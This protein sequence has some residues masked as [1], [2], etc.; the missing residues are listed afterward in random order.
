MTTERCGNF[1]ERTIADVESTD[2]ARNLGL[3]PTDR[4]DGAP[5]PRLHGFRRGVFRSRVVSDHVELELLVSD[6]GVIEVAGLWIQRRWISDASQL[7]T[8]IDVYARFLQDAVGEVEAKDRE[9]LGNLL[10]VSYEQVKAFDALL[11]RFSFVPRD[12]VGAAA[13]VLLGRRMDASTMIRTRTVTVALRNDTSGR[14]YVGVA[15]AKAAF[16]LGDMLFHAAP[17]FTRGDRAGVVGWRAPDIENTPFGRRFSLELDRAAP[18]QG[19]IARRYYGSAKVPGSI[20]LEVMMEPTRGLAGVLLKLEQAWM[21][22]SDRNFFAALEIIAAFVCEG[23]GDSPDARARVE[24]GDFLSVSDD[25]DDLWKVLKASLP[26]VARGKNGD[27]LEVFL[28]ERESAATFMDDDRCAVVI[29]ENEDGWL[30]VLFHLTEL[31]EDIGAPAVA[32][33]EKP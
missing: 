4:G 2:F 28:G 33:P 14:M 7:G 1:L 16:E 21:E 29:H 32:A 19:R 15:T 23:L 24:I 11:R 10:A 3:F 9:A 31:H 20:K 8:V 25:D 27:G 22:R 6:R 13:E 26:F 12:G 30:D 5:D 18:P 17:S